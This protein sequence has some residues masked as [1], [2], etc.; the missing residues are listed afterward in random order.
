MQLDRGP[1]AS[2]M[3]A[4]LQRGPLRSAGTVRCGSALG[5][6]HVAREELRRSSLGRRSTH[7]LS[8]C[9]AK[10]F[11]HE[12]LKVLTGLPHVVDVETLLPLA[13]TVQDQT[14]RSLVGT[15][16]RV[17]EHP[18]RDVVVYLPRELRSC[19]QDSDGHVASL[20][21]M[22][23]PRFYE[24]RLASASASSTDRARPSAASISA[25]QCR[26]C[27]VRSPRRISDT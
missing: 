18:L 9:R 8:H 14:V 22:W 10:S 4:A 7:H 20:A 13:R 11:L 19:C 3:E 21:C 12:A 1:V 5:D 15:H 2:A 25:C 24:S 17:P 6:K 27:R 26:G 16:R 23:E